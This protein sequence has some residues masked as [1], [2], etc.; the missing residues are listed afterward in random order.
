MHYL[1]IILSVQAKLQ[2]YFTLDHVVKLR[3]GVNLCCVL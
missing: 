2:K 3:S 1:L